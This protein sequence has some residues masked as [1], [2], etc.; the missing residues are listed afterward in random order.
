MKRSLDESIII[1][2]MRDLLNKNSNERAD[3]LQFFL[4]HG[5]EELCSAAGLDAKT[6][7]AKVVEAA[8]HDGVRREKLVKDLIRVLPKD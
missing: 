5:H 8:K 3:A 6:I 7:R 1:Q 4:A 2:A